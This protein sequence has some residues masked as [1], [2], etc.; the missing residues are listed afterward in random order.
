MTGAVDN[1]PALTDTNIV[2]YA[3]DPE[4]APRHQ[5]AIELLESLSDA[6]CLVLSAQVL[7]EFCSVMMRPKRPTPLTPEEVL[8]IIRD[9]VATADVVPITSVIT[10]RALEAMPRHGFSFWDALIWAA[11]AENGIPTVY[12][13]DFQHGREIE[14]VR[15]VNPF[16]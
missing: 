5:R 9:L 3:Y 1:A 16:L 15:F 8:E 6:G 11:A 2:V 14:S 7:N 12:S 10:L 13:E 4:D